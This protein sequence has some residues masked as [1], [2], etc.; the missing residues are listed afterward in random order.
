LN[1]RKLDAV[2]IRPQANLW[3]FARLYR[4]I[5]W[6]RV[7]SIG[8]SPMLLVAKRRHVTF[9]TRPVPAGFWKRLRST[10][11]SQTR[12]RHRFVWSRKLTSSRWRP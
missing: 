9:A 4:G 1:E 7:R 3:M 8:L 10:A 2:S 6:Q 12:L 11:W 5:A